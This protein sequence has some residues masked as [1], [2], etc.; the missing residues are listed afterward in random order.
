MTSLE[1]QKRIKV[2]ETLTNVSRF[3]D[4]PETTQMR[5]EKELARI[6]EQIADLNK[7]LK[8]S[9]PIWVEGAV[10]R[11]NG[12][13][14]MLK[15]PRT[16]KKMEAERLHRLLELSDEDLFGKPRP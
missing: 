4:N 16:N 1:E 5:L 2:K 15:D 10:D 14:V 12:I 3:L 11:L 9:P 6:D 8:H 7:W 13:I